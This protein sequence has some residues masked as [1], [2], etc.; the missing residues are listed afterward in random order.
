MFQIG[1]WN[2]LWRELLPIAKMTT[3][4]TLLAEAAL[5]NWPLWEMEVRTH[6][7]M[8]TYM[9]QSICNLL[10]SKFFPQ[11]K[12]IIHE[13]LFSFLFFSFLIFGRSIWKSLHG[14][15]QAR[16]AMFD[17]FRNA[18]IQKKRKKDKFRSAILQ[19]TFYQSQDDSSL[20]IRWTSRAWTKLLICA[21]EMN[22]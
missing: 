18:T 22:W 10:R 9:K 6:F 1:I 5:N 19:A 12:P 20:F 11:N 2:W 13:N 3:A 7:F 17:K 14:L 15:K 8:V 16:W 4:R 21:D